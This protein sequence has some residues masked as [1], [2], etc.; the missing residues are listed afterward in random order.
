M[1]KNIYSSFISNCLNLE[2]TEC[3]I[4]TNWT[5]FIY[6]YNRLHSDENKWT[7]ATGNNME[8]SHK[9]IECEELDCNKY[10]LYNSICK[11]QKHAKQTCCFRSR[12]SDSVSS[13]EVRA[14]GKWGS[15]KCISLWP[16]IGMMSGWSFTELYVCNLFTYEYITINYFLKVSDI[17]RNVIHLHIM[18]FKTLFL[19]TCPLPAT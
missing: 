3:P 6:S 5:H 13:N 9:Y 1:N 16:Y 2:T 18:V 11:V 8:T 15:L 12:D 4:T 10:M 7:L 19:F 14:G 17:H